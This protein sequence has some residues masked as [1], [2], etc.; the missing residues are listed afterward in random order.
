MCQVRFSRKQ[1]PR[2]VDIQELFGEKHLQRIKGT[3]QRQ[4]GRAFRMG[5]KQDIYKRKRGKERGKEE[6]IGSISDC[7]TAQ[8]QFQ[9]G[10]WGILGAKPSVRGDPHP[11]DGLVLYHKCR[12]SLAGSSLRDVQPWH[13]SAGGSRGVAAGAV[14]QLCSLYERSEW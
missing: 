11:C 13:E 4:G 2:R 9:P 14:S 1:A 10:W 7:S 8:G 12:R 6:S 5:Y 3:K